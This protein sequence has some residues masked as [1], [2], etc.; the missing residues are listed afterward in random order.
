MEINK[1]NF[2]KIYNFKDRLIGFAREIIL[3]VRQF[4]KLYELDYYTNQL[5]RK[6]LFQLW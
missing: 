5:I 3:F 6:C 2:N 4:E 1:P